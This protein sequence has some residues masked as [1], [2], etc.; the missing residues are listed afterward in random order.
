MIQI[1]SSN[2]EKL[3]F[4]M[5][6]DG[7]SPSEVSAKLRVYHEGIE[8]GFK[9]DTGAGSSMNVTLPPL[10][11]VIPS[12]KNKAVLEA[13]LEVVANGESFLTAWDDQLYIEKPIQMKA[14]VTEK[15][16]VPTKKLSAKAAKVT[17]ESM[18]PQ[19]AG[20][21]VPDPT[22]IASAEDIE[23]NID[24]SM[25]GDTMTDMPIQ[26][27]ETTELSQ[28]TS[29]PTRTGSLKREDIDKLVELQLNKLL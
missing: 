10:D 14:A 21:M 16:E 8:Y 25:D 9:V 24:E 29:D 17:R 5:S 26:Q 1:K 2:E 13:R 23:E 6:I 15:A 18:P 19:P 3:T 22:L 11:T 4:E 20:D 7:A 27:L 12:L 28:A